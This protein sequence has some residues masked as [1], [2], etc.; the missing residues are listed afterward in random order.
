MLNDIQT[1]SF[2]GSQ[3]NIKNPYTEAYN[4]TFQRS[5]TNN[6]VATVGYVGNETRHVVVNVNLNSPE[7]LI[8]P[9]VS[10][11]TVE[12]FPSFGSAGTNEY[13]GIS[14]YNALQAAIEK[15]YA[16]GLSFSASYTWAHSMDDASQP[17]GGNGY[18]AVNLIGLRADYANS[19]A[20]V[21]NRVTFNG[22]YDLPFGSG[23]KFLTHRGILSAILGGWSDDLQFTAQTGFPFSVGTDLGSAGPNGGGAFA[24]LTRDPFASGGAP[25]PSNSTTACATSTRNRTH[26]YN[27]C[28]F[29]NPP[30]AFPNA[31]VKG[32]PVSTTLIEG[33][34]ALPYLGEGPYA[35]HGPGYERINTS[36]FKKVPVFREDYVELRA[37]IFNV[38]NAPSLANPSTSGDASTGGLITGPQT[39]QNFTP[40]ARFIQLSGK[41][42]F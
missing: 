27:P 9:R 34:A 14:T 20:D 3:P 30:L 42:V 19:Q 6:M 22:Y 7:A 24:I 18:R 36:L 38:L 10:T 2:A 23:K 25:D 15:R 41:F 13:T 35:I 16:S 8:D 31:S 4:L 37:D 39:F 28:A 33:T 11:Q 17:L 21:R 5:L 40:D 29:A 26:W 32:S 12:P 1:P